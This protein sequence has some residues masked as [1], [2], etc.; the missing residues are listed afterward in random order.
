MRDSSL[1]HTQSIK[2]ESYS[3]IG[4][5]LTKHKIDTREIVVGIVDI[6]CVIEMD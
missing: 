1:T 5:I 6:D 2:L 3:M 4:L